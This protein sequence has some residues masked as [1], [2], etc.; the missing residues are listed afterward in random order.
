MRTFLTLEGDISPFGIAMLPSTVSKPFGHTPP[1]ATKIWLVKLLK[2]H[3]HSFKQIVEKRNIQTLANNF[4]YPWQVGLDF[5]ENIWL[6]WMWS[7]DATWMNRLIAN[8]PN[9]H[10][11]AILIHSENVPKTPSF[12]KT[13]WSPTLF[14]FQYFYTDIS[15]ISVTFCNSSPGSHSDSQ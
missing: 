13:A 3:Q 12:Y 6:L 10:L 8:D 1:T 11:V 5:S 2:K 14:T 7:A 15:A 9:H 4:L